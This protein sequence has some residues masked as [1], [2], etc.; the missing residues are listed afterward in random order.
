MTSP[1]STR[2]REQEG[3]RYAFTSSYFT[4]GPPPFCFS[5]FPH[6]NCN[7]LFRRR[8]E[9]KKWAC[10]WRVWCGHWK[11]FSKF[12]PLPLKE[13]DRIRKE[14]GERGMIKSSRTVETERDSQF[15]GFF[16]DF[17][18]FVVSEICLKL[19]HEVSGC[20]T[21]A[22]PLLFSVSCVEEI[23]K[24]GYDTYQRR[25]LTDVKM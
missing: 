23:R 3:E 10:D 24:S 21:L 17:W 12:L 20:G 13:Q 15:I 2:M 16:S 9:R 8:T 7:S 4:L 19:K 18:C 25:L 1:L 22:G 11:E 14:E 6:S 5:F